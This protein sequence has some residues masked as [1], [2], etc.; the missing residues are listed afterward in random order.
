MQQQEQIQ[1][2]SD[3]GQQVKWKIEHRINRFPR[4][5]VENTS[6]PYLFSPNF[7]YQLDFN[8]SKRQF[9]I[10]AMKTQFLYMEI[11]KDLLSTSWK[12]SSNL[13]S[14]KI[15]CSRFLWISDRKFRIVNQ[16]NLDCIFEICDDQGKEKP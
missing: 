10:I 11:P 16:A 1:S 7:E 8:V 13:E 12:N 9:V 15:I 4:N 14:L 5:L 2:S 3:S 6:V